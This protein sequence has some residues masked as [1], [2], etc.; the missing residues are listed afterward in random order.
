MVVGGHADVMSVQMRPAWETLE[1]S[2]VRPRAQ[3]AKLLAWA[4]SAGQASWTHGFPNSNLCSL[5]PVT[6][7][8]WASVL[9]SV[10]WEQA[11]LEET[12]DC[13]LPV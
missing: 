4:R 1:N 7:P 5:G 12:G 11:G 10:K 9:P 2:L 3:P 13:K 6:R 8:L